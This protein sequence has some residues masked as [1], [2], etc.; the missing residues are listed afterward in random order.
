M[1]KTELL[2]EL[3]AENARWEA[4]LS[5]IGEERMTQPGVAGDWSVKDIIAHLAGWRRRTVARLRAASRHEPEPPSPWPAN[6]QEDDEINN[7]IYETNRD[8]SLSDVLADSRQLFQQIVEALSAFPEKELQD[9]RRFPWME[10]A[11]LSGRLF[12]EHFRTEHEPDMRAWAA[13]GR[14]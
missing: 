6:L 2:D 9:P 3:K 12:F 13:K 5:E 1:T 4:L 8:R 7:W 10:G 14:I 11:P